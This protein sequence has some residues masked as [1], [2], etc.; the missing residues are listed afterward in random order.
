MDI[1]SA[2]NPGF[3]GGNFFWWVG[4]IADKSYWDKNM[5][6]GKFADP[7][8]IPGWGGRRKVRIIGLHPQ[9]EE[10]LS[11]DKLPWAQIMY[12]VTAGGGQSSSKQTANLRQGM[13]VFGFFLDGTEQQVPVIMGVLGN[14][15]QTKLIRTLGEKG[16]HNFKPI[17][18][19]AQSPSDEGE[20]EKV[21]DR[22]IA[23][24]QGTNVTIES[25]DG[26]EHQ[27]SVADALHQEEMNK[28]VCVI[29]K[30]NGNLVQSALTSIQTV[31]DKITEKIDKRLAQAYSYIDAASERI[32]DLRKYIANLACEITKYMKIIFDQMM[33]FELK[34]L[35][36]SLI[37]A[38]AS[39]P[40]SV[41]SLATELKE[42]ITSLL[43]CLYNNMVNCAMVQ[44]MLDKMFN[45]DEME[46]NNKDVGDRQKPKAPMCVAEG[47][48]TALIIEN[49]DSINKANKNILDSIDGFLGD[50][51]GKLADVRNTLGVV[52][53]AVDTMS[54]DIMS[55]ITSMVG[56]ISS[57]LNF[58]NISFNIFGCEFKPIPRTS[59]IYQFAM[60]GMGAGEGSFPDIAKI[61]DQIVSDIDE[62]DM[63]IDDAIKPYTDAAD[64]FLEAAD[65]NNLDKA[66]TDE[67]TRVAEDRY[68][69]PSAD[70][71]DSKY[72][73]G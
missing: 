61:T 65:I 64:N 38:I 39:L 10:E 36:A 16:E 28:K 8:S 21:P 32:A 25:N 17:S 26:T 18:G 15:S 12:P 69:E 3:L 46:K 50:V 7:T 49:K 14:N 11:S 63:G 45:L 29:K 66:I 2:F 51:E 37:N 55:Q 71:P 68:A 44:K 53:S 22:S 5:P 59:D 23:V 48:T 67:L 30:Q 57:A 4:Q 47:L 42:K 72:T 58:S 60:G 40:C 73:G 70:E 9:S 41:R 43:E 20:P 35:N 54:T 34:K 13:F 24:S 56:N 27:Q 52:D 31:L 62:F 19:S 6:S 33:E 1:G